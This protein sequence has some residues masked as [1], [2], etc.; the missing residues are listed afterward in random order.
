[1]VMPQALPMGQ[2]GLAIFGQKN[3]RSWVLVGPFKRPPR[4][5]P[6]QSAHLRGH[7]GRRLVK[8]V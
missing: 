7:H 8:S 2:R 1:M 5:T 3:T 4:Q 6:R